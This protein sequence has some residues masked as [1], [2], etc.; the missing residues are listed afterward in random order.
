M[1]R[2]AAGHRAAERRHLLILTA[3]WL[4]AA[5]IVNPAGN[6]PLSD[7][8]SYAHSVR[9]L[10]AQHE[11]RL[12]DF[13]S[14]PIGTQL[15]W[16]AVFCL[17]A[18]FS[19]VALRVSTLV[20]AWLT[21]VGVYRLLRACGSH[22]TCALIAA[23][24]VL[25][26]PVVFALAFTFMTDIPALAFGVWACVFAVRHADRPRWLTLCAATALF[27]AATLVRQISVTIAVGAAMAFIA[28]ARSRRG[29]LDAIVV[30][31]CPVAALLAY[32]AFLSR[33]GLPL[34][35]DVHDRDVAALLTAGPVGLVT[36]VLS[37][38][39]HSY[40]YV[41][42]FLLPIAAL[43]VWPPMPGRRRHRIGTAAVAAV[44]FLL[45]GAV[46]LVRRHPLPF[47]PHILHDTGLNPIMI[48]RDDLWPRTPAMLW[49]L[50][51]VAAGISAGLITWRLIEGLADSWTRRAPARAA[52]VLCVAA[53]G[54]YLVPL[55]ILSAL[56]DRYL[57]VPMVLTLALL[58][59]AGAFHEAPRPGRVVAA[60]AVLILT[61]AFD[62]A[63]THDLLTFN[64]ARWTAV[65]A[66][67]GDGVPAEQIDGGY[68]VDR[69]LTYR[70]PVTIAEI[71]TWWNR[72][73]AP[74]AIVSLGPMAGYETARRYPFA[75][76]LSADAGPDAS[77][78]YV[79]RKHR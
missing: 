49:I 30:I 41:G 2:G 12:T 5:A 42:L 50:L 27:V 69:W 60:A 38:S 75:R 17:P 54:A 70:P 52:I 18:G 62:I 16:G 13:T 76:W 56:L 64:R 6:F 47:L 74:E 48:A 72:R 73:D 11:W 19:F 24:S 33:T 4:A 66:L 8:W 59:L 57:L 32:N 79:L 36:T 51:T 44:G 21:G 23:A 29:F 43:V 65:D 31:L 71:N 22:Q 46:M 7:D 78:V 25:F 40:I 63:A 55:F 35:Y 68:E 20:L 58:A 77:A 15:L 53:L 37:R 1:S 9:T 26:C 67:L 3:A 61:A 14:V 39:L 28:R 10:L 45:P 34:L